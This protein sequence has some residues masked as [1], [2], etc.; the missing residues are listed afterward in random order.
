MAEQ[1][2]PPSSR[3][4]SPSASS[5]S[6]FRRER[7]KSGSRSIDI[8]E[9]IELRTS[10]HSKQKNVQHTHSDDVFYGE[11]VLHR[12]PLQ[13]S[14]G[15]VTSTNPRGPVLRH[16]RQ[17]GHEEEEH[18]ELSKNDSHV[19]LHDIRQSRWIQN[20]NNAAAEKIYLTTEAGPLSEMSTIATDFCWVHHRRHPGDMHFEDFV[21]GLAR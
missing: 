2:L 21:V 8:G 7:R 5:K 12:T 9:H 13:I 4:V 10:Q 3:P 11:S 19:T 17:H 1:T 14:P 15:E 18:A 6:P 16:V 20:P